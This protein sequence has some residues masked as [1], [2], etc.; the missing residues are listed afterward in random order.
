MCLFE[1]WKHKLRSGFLPLFFLGFTSSGCFKFQQC[2]LSKIWPT[3]FT[4]RRIFWKSRLG[5]LWSSKNLATL[6]SLPLYYL[7]PLPIVFNSTNTRVS[8]FSS[9]SWLKVF[10][11]QNFETSWHDGHDAGMNLGNV[12]NYFVAREPWYRNYCRRCSP[13]C[14]WISRH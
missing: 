11:K 8:H 5:F 14:L 13:S 1:Y 6:F 3:V 2:Q 12:K 9:V 10:R 4:Q 7:S